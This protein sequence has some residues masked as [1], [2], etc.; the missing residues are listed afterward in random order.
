[1][2]L[3]TKEDDIYINIPSDLVNKINEDNIF[4]K[5]YIRIYKKTEK[6]KEYIIK[7]L[8]EK[9]TAITQ[10][11]IGDLLLDIKSEENL[12][13]FINYIDVD[14]HSLEEKFKNLS[15][16]LYLYLDVYLNF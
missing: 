3:Y 11:N 6:L 5:E 14:I 12:D 16:H 2:K 15:I 13:K 10:K 4:L 8:F 9:D 1:M 7:Y